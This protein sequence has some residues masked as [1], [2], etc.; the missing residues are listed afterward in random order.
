MSDFLAPVVNPPLIVRTKEQ[1][2]SLRSYAKSMGFPERIYEDF[3]IYANY[4]VPKIKV[5]KN[6]YDWIWVH[7]YICQNFNQAIFGNGTLLTIELGP[8]IGKSILTALFISFVH[9][10]S[11]DSSII[12]ATYNETKAIDFTKRYVIKFMTTDKYKS[13]FPHVAFK[14]EQD[15]KDNSAERKA[16]SKTSTMKDTEYTLSNLKTK[17]NYL[18]GYRCFGLDQ[19]IHGIPGDIFIID[20]YVDKGDSV[21]SENFRN[22][23]SE[24]FYNDMPSRLQDNSS[25]VIAICTRWYYNDIIGMLHSAYDN[26]IV[27]DCLEA[28]IVPP[29]LNKVRIRA[30]YRITDNNPPCDPRTKDGEKLWSVHTLKYALAKKGAY[31]QA[32]YNCDPSDTDSTQQLKATDFGYY[33]EIPDI[34]GRYMFSIDGASTNN[35][36]SD[37]TAI[38]YWFV[39]GF[40]RYLIK[41]WYIKMETPELTRFVKGLLDEYDYDECLIEFAS[42]G[43]PLSQSLKDEHYNNITQLGFSGRPIESNAKTK[44]KDKIAKGN[45]KMERYLRC[46]PEFLFEDKRILLPKNEIEHQK[47]FVQQ[48]TTFDGVDG[49][50]DDMVDMATYL[51]YYTSRQV[52][53]KTKVSPPSNN[54]PQ[55]NMGMNYGMFSPMGRFIGR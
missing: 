53:K 27:P 34:A 13:I 18:G 52:V 41:L 25:I 17:K 23:R 45:S 37:H 24:W 20:D 28:G 4:M 36:N 6:F 51:I 16:Q 21:R 39:S 38:G 5:G 50:A 40:Q 10:V 31:Y 3:G 43:I 48:L 47:T 33:D 26:D 35:K 46:I 22:K 32:M 12:Y 14:Y 11:P 2:N 30:E 55:H 42:A 29:V 1:I 9:G 44:N 15:Q 49:K 19:G 7:W 54:N 8:Q